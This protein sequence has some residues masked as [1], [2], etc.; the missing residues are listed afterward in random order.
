[1]H[2]FTCFSSSNQFWMFFLSEPWKAI[3][4]DPTSERT[5]SLEV[6]H[7][8]RSAKY[9]GYVEGVEKKYHC[10]VKAKNLSRSEVNGL[11]RKYIKMWV[12]NF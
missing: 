3:V 2:H 1:M 7:K 9:P 6:E 11:I 12:K 10:Y 8:K 4:L 5:K